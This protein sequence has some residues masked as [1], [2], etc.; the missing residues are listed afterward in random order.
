MIGKNH[1]NNLVSNLQSAIARIRIFV[2][3]KSKPPLVRLHE[4]IPGQA[5]DFFVLLTDKIRGAR[6]DGK[7]FYTCRFRD[8]AR[9]ASFMV[10]SDGPWFE[11]CEHDWQ[12]G[13]FYK[14]RGSYDE[15]KVYGPQIDIHNLRSAGEQDREDGFNPAD[16]VEY[17]RFDPK[18]MFAELV[19]LAETQIVNAPLRKLVV[20]LLERHAGSLQCLPAT[21]K[22]FHPFHGGLL[23]H[24]LSVTHSCLQLVDKYSA[25]YPDLQPPLNRDLVV[26]GAILHDIGRVVEFADDTTNTQTT[27]PGRLLGHIILGRDLVRDTARELGDVDPELLQLLEHL[28]V[29][30]LNLPEWGSPRLPLI[31]ECLILHHADDLDA[32][33]EMY[34]RCLRRDKEEGPFTARDPVL[35]KQLYKGRSV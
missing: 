23:E 25:H 32:K 22:N 3:S 30:H 17:S 31:P 6:R 16:F 15:H 24:I 14:I 21:L 29:T 20:T 34:A 2:M 27:V 35:G 10:W 12:E 4:M 9:T 7:P 18:A 1:S 33:L 26:A 19:D 8:H 28:I 5:G 13:Q 11:A